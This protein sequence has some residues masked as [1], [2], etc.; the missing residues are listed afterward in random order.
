MKF[1][2]IEEA[3]KY[4]KLSVSGLKYHLYPERDLCP[5]RIGQS[6]TLVFTQEMLDTFQANRRKP[7]RPKKSEMEM[8]EAEAT[9]KLLH[10]LAS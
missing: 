8:E 7:G 1:Y 6:R 5:I 9:A 10:W 2:G 3:A 4:L